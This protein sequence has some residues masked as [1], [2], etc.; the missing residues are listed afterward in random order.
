[1]TLYIEMVS[2]VVCPWCWLGLR[3]ANEAR[4]MLPDL[5]VELL[6]RPY[7][8]DPSIPAGG[9]DY[10]AYMQAKFGANEETKSR[11]NSMRDMLV[12]FGEQ[13]GISFQFDA[14]KR[15]PNTF[16]AHRL[17]SWAQGQGKGEAAKE[18]LFEAVFANAQDIGL[19][20]VLVSIAGKIGLDANLVSYLLL[21]DADKDRLRKEQALFLQMGVSGVPTFIANRQFAISGAQD[22]D[23][24]AQFFQ[25]A[26]AENPAAA[27]N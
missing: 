15:R 14:I 3:R 4:Q 26:A 22:A 19:H 8:L 12:E 1:M 7:E 11:A 18:A 17:I 13:A 2:D 10:K 5:D 25:K 9:T 6:F 20:E 21:S 27:V 16:D 23:V 24:L